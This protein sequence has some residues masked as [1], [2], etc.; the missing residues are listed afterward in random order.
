MMS[1]RETPVA[2]RAGIS[3]LRRASGPHRSHRD[4]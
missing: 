2:V 4:L 3:W 1:R